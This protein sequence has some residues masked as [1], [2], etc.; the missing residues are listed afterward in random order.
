MYLCENTKQ[1]MSVFPLLAYT[2]CLNVFGR[3]T[4]SEGKTWDN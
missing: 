1:E 3:R 2:I 4:A